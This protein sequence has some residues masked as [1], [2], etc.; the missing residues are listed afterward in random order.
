MVGM[1][2]A[3]VITVSL[4]RETDDRRAYSTRGQLFD[5]AVDGLAIVTRTT[6][7][8]MD[9][10]RVLLG[11]GTA[12]ATP[13]ALR[14]AGSAADA[15]RSTVGAA[16]GLTIKDDSVGKPVFRQWS[17]SPFNGGTAVPGSPPV[18]PAEVPAL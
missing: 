4:V 10:A 8:L 11:D 14:H 15:L 2:E 9:A 6:Q 18:R 7:P 12:P 17:P 16:A 13:L 1:G 5:G 3:I